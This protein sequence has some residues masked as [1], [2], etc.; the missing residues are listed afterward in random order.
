M[1]DCQKNGKIKQIGSTPHEKP[2][3]GTTFPKPLNFKKKKDSNKNALNAGHINS[4][5]DQSI[6]SWPLEPLATQLARRSRRNESA[7]DLIHAYA[8]A[9]LDEKTIKLI[10][11]SSGHKL[12]A[13]NKGFFWLSNFL[14]E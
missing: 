9:T 5:T 3:Y 6:D 7:I 11:F 14:T 10:E 8:R 2:N 1:N 12:L 13:F 4:N